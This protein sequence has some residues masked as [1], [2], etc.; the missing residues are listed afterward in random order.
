MPKAIRPQKPELDEDCW[1]FLQAFYDLSTCR[2]VGGET[3]GDIPYTAILMWIKAW[4][5][6]REDAEFYL[7]IIPR[8]DRVY[9]NHVYKKREE[10]LEQANRGRSKT[11]GTGVKPI[12]R[13][14]R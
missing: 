6:G 8:L 3:V 1:V 12:R 4:N 5:I 7:E 9:L 14:R 2:S 13:T 11:L 10:S